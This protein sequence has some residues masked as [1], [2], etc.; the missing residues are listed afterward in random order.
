MKNIIKILLLIILFAV[1]TNTVFANE[2]YAVIKT[3]SLDTTVRMRKK[4]STLASDGDYGWTNTGALHKLV[5]T[6]LHENKYG[7]PNGWYK[8]YYSGT[9]TAYMCSDYVD[10]I[11]SK[12]DGTPPLSA[13]EKEMANLGF[14]SSYWAGLCYLKNKYPNW[15]FKNIKTNLDWKTAVEAEAACKVSYVQSSNDEY[16]DPTCKGDEAKGWDPASKLAV[17]RAMDPRYFL[18]PRRIFMFEEL[19]YDEK[20]SNKYEDATY[21]ILKN[22][23][24]YSLHKGYIV[25]DV[26]TAGRNT[27]TSPIHLSSRMLQELGSSDTLYNLY[28][29]KTAGYLNLYNFF[30]FGVTDK[31]AKEKGTTKCGLDYASDRGWNSVYNAIYGAASQI[32]RNYINVGQD[33]LYFQKFN[34]NPSDRNKLYTHQYMTNIFAPLSESGTTFSTLI[35][36]DLMDIN[37]VFSIPTYNNMNISIDNS[38]SGASGSGND[39]LSSLPIS[40]I[41][42]SSGF[43]YTKNTISEILPNTNTNTIKNKL[44][45]K[46]GKGNVVVYN[47][48]GVVVEDKL[49]GTG[50]KIKIKNETGD[51]TL[52][53]IVKGDTSGDGVISALDLLQIQKHILGVNKLSNVYLEAGDTSGDGKV[54][55]LDLL[56]F[57]KHI[58]DISKI[59]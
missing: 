44:E 35:N 43:K 58:L 20:L 29:G 36:L 13:C 9:K 25:N 53:V 23:N 12:K 46:A 27:S 6:D 32:S 41:V 54:N 50:Y 40:T 17:S 49:M 33:T 37:Y 22:T 45:S 51:E 21:N 10:V 8:F 42:T 14:P 7:C 19:S 38:G 56:Q 52:S 15:Q 31:C 1:F 26:V 48:N 28:S 3:K 39:P 47:K 30:N 55:A 5:N 18:S 11:E 59:K 34:V 57:Q 2:Y 24:F 16:K 4:P